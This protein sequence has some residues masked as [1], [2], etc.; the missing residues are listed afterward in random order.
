MCV[1]WVCDVCGYSVC[2][3]T[4]TRIQILT[5]LLS[6]RH[7]EGRLVNGAD[8]GG[9]NSRYSVYLLYWYKSTNTDALSLS[10]CGADPPKVSSLV[11]RASTTNTDN[12]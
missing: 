6:R 8:S 9:A 7:G 10:A 1:C 4:S 3:L 2:V 5:Q 11:L 12:Q